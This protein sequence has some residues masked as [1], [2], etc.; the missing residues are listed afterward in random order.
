MP[1]LQMV[2]LQAQKA[3][4]GLPK[5]K[6]HSRVMPDSLIRPCTLVRHKFVSCHE[7]SVRG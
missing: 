1:V 6:N 7:L 2:A 4:D 5:V 3:E